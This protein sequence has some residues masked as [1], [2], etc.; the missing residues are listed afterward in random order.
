MLV[1]VRFVVPGLEMV[2]NF[3][4]L[5]P[6]GTLPKLKLPASAIVCPMPVP[7]AGREF[8]PVVADELTVT[9]PE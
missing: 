6:T 9:V 5:V 8:T 2:S 3:C 7:E 4:A 1:T